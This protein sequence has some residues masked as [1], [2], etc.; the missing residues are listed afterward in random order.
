MRA[1]LGIA[2]V[3][4]FGVAACGGPPEANKPAGPAP[5]SAPAYDRQDGFAG[6]VR[7]A[8]SVADEG[9]SLFSTPWPTELRRHEDG[10]VDLTVFPGRDHFALSSLFDELEGHV[11]GFSIAPVI[12]VAFEGPIKRAAVARA[13][14]RGAIRLV[15]VDPE[16]PTRGRRFPLRFRLVEG[17][18]HVPDGTLA[19]RPEEVLAPGRLHALVV[20]RR[21]SPDDEPLG[22]S[23]ELERV[24]ST[25]P[26]ADAK[27]ER[28]R[29]LHAP[30]FGWLEEQGTPRA[31][32]GGVAVFR[33]QPAQQPVASL[34][35]AVTHLTASANVTGAHGAMQPIVLRAA[36]DD[37]AEGPH[38]RVV[39]GYYCTPNFQTGLE[40]APFVQDGGLIEHD[41]SGQPKP[42]AIPASS[43]Y[44]AAE[45]GGR[46]RARFVLTV[47]KGSMPAEGWPLMVYAHGTTGDARSALDGGFAAVAARAGMASVSTD[48]P[49][50]GSGDPMGARP[51]SNNPFAFKLGR[52][53]IPLP[54]KGKGGELAFYNIRM[55]VLRDN[56]RQ[57]IADGAVLARLVLATD[58]ATAKRPDGSDALPAR[59][60]A[61]RPHFHRELGYVAVGHSQGS[62]SMA[63]LG[64]LD[65]LARAALLSA[66]GGD[67]SSATLL[68]DDAA[69]VRPL[70]ELVL[71]LAAGELDEFHP[72][73]TLVQTMLDPVDPQTFGVG[74]RD[75]KQPKSALLVSGR[76]DTMVVDKAGMALARAMGLQPIAPLVFGQA[77]L[78]AAGI[79]ATPIVL[80]N[81][82]ERRSTLAWLQLEPS[83][84][85]EPHFVAFREPVAQKVMEAFL[86]ALARGQGAP[87]LSR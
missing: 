72:F 7:V 69:K 40:D 36:W 24:K 85:Y 70:V 26:Q 80:E 47:P 29:A 74:Y 4:A 27:L 66:G 71:G 82:P 10:R 12:Y 6:A 2:C 35:E 52:V 68:R 22:T 45:C 67:F 65:P 41:A 50:H 17:A 14:E 81:G 18:R 43:E 48:Q 46:M 75:A 49:L 84:R 53:P 25:V 42:F 23:G 79:E 64:A 44:H 3:L 73:A 32:V 1:A 38:H 77:E 13:L 60:D 76:G 54:L 11:L 31:E 55:G 62:Q 57:A 83:Y 9:R 63:A 19:L 39:S 86:G 61:E 30:V 28:A 87:A 33:T 34:L 16:S 58:F 78:A 56:L 51:G 21:W 59:L 5:T 20:E 37:G 8:F 15:D